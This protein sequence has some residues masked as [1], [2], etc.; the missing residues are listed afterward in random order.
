MTDPTNYLV[1][2]HAL[3]DN[4][5]TR[6][7]RP[8]NPNSEL[9]M[10]RL[11]DRVGM[12]RAL[13]NL[14]RIPPGKESFVPHAHSVQEE[15]LFILEGQGTALIGDAE[16]PVGPGDYMGF[17]TDGTAH[18]LINTGDSDLLYLMGGE[19]TEQETI[20]FPTLG[21]T[22]VFDAKE[23]RFFNGTEDDGSGER[24]NI[25]DWVRENIDDA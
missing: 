1:R 23:V 18:H 10:W 20:T 19:R 25:E 6:I 21:Q 4:D 8:Q 12:Q 3:T 2:T 11:G 14:V 16:V 13:L 17:P 15:F 9:T 22:G 5:G 24:Q 7:K